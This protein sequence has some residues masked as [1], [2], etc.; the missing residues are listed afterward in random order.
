MNEVQGGNHSHTTS[1]RKPGDTG[2]DMRNMQQPQLRSGGGDEADISSHRLT[3]MLGNIK[4]P[5]NGFNP[6]VYAACPSAVPS[7]LHRMAVQP[8]ARG[9]GPMSPPQS[10]TSGTIGTL[11]DGSDILTH[12]YMCNEHMDT[13]GRT[14]FDLISQTGNAQM[15]QFAEKHK[16]LARTLEN[17]FEETKSQLTSTDQKADEVSVQNKVVIGKLDQVLDLIKGDVL[18]QLANQTRKNA[19]MEK[20]IKGLQKTVQELKLF[21][22]SSP[23][24]VHGQPSQS[25][26]PSF[27]PGLPNH[28]SQPSL[29]NFYGGPADSGRGDYTRMNHGQDMRENGHYRYNNNNGN[30][31]NWYRPQTSAGENK[32]RGQAYPSSNPYQNHNGG[33]GNSSGGFYGGV[34]G[35][36]SARPRL[37]P[38]NTR[39]AD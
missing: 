10:G 21:V 39:F 24:P 12:F 30:N 3:D 6:D 2:I 1:P 23:P 9:P 20:E 37:T 26:Q 31:P 11:S 22:E 38:Y 32:D 29:V 17:R 13:M 19:E 15:N 36:V 28:R 14:L 18:E 34:P 16:A 7:P 33:Q 27:P 5:K 35:Y 4:A 8:P 25:G